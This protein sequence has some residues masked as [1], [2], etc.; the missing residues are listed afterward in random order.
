MGAFALCLTFLLFS[1]FFCQ[2]LEYSQQDAAARLLVYD[3]F[4]GESHR[5]GTVAAALVGYGCTT[6]CGVSHGCKGCV[7]HG[8][9]YLWVGGGI[10]LVVQLIVIAEDL[11]QS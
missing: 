8:L 5:K 7:A 10:V 4:Q 1:L 9:Q 2:E 11:A 6:A 3:A